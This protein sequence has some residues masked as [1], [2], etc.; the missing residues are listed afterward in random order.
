M[1]W[2][3]KSPASRP[4]IGT[5]CAPTLGFHTYFR[6]TASHP[7]AVRP[8]RWEGLRGRAGQDL[9]G[10]LMHILCVSFA[11]LGGASGDRL[12]PTETPKAPDLDRPLAGDFPPGWAGGEKKKQKC[13]ASIEACFCN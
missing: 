11:G 12:T 5:G 10:K 6:L 1:Y 3:W 2:I 13:I 9:S 7:R 4:L 8:K